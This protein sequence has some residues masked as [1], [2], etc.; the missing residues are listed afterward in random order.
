MSIRGT[1]EAVEVI[2]PSPRFTEIS[3]GV[4]GIRVEESCMTIKLTIIVPYADME[5]VRDIFVGA[6]HENM[7]M[8]PPMVDITTVS[9]FIPKPSLDLKDSPTTKVDHW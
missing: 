8:P 6:S 9:S 2:Q 1:V 4:G 3:D 5:K 7:F